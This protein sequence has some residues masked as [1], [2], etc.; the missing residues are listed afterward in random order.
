MDGAVNYMEK[1]HPTDS[2]IDDD[3]VE[4]FREKFITNP[5]VIEN[6]NPDSVDKLINLFRNRL[7][8]A[9]CLIAEANISDQYVVSLTD[10]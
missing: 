3:D 2:D 5:Q 6:V 7:S 10:G 8:P 4:L 9:E 1:N